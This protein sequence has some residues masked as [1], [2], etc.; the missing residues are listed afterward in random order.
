[1]TTM[2]RKYQNET[3]YKN[4]LIIKPDTKWPGTTLLETHLLLPRKFFWLKL[5]V[6]TSGWHNAVWHK[7]AMHR[8]SCSYPK[9]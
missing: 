4:K 1:M 5:Y 3:K 2:V 9:F 6:S 8:I 7:L